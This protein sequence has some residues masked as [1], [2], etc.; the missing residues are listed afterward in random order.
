MLK[1][2]IVLL[3][4]LCSFGLTIAM[5]N[6]N[7]ISNEAVSA[8]MDENRGFEQNLGQVGDFDGNPV[9]NILFTARNNGFSIFIT[10]KGVS[11]VIY[12]S[13]KTPEDEISELP[14]S[15][16]QSARLH[17]ARI[18]LE[19]I[20]SRIESANVVYEDEL[21][22]YT[23]YYLPQCPDG[24]LF[25]K[26]YRK[27]RIKEVYPGIDWVWRYKE[28]R[29]HH[30]FELSEDADISKIKFRVKY[31]D[32]EVKDGKKLILSTPIGK[33][34]DGNVIGYEG[35]SPVEVCYKIAEDGL[36]GFDV[37]AWSRK[38]RLIIDPTLALLWGTYYG[39]SDYDQGYSITT[40]GSGNIL[41]TGWT[42]S[43]DF[44]TQD[45]GGGAYYQGTLGEHFDVFIL[46]FANTGVRV[47]AT[48]YGGSSSDEGNSITTDGSGN[49]L[50]TGETYSADFPTQDP[51]G[52]AYY[53]GTN[54]GEDDVV[55]L[56][57]T[58]TG[59]R[60]W[61]TYYGGNGEDWG[62]SITTDGS[63]NILVTGYIKSTDF[64]TQNLG[65]GAY[66]QGAN[67]GNYDAFILKFTNA[68]IRV[69]G[70]YYGGSDDDYGNSITT[71][72]SGNILVTGYTWS[73]DFPTQNPGGG[74]YYQGT[75]AGGYWD[76][77][78]LKFTNTGVRVW[79][80]YY[81]GSDYD[82]GNSIT[83]DGSG[84]I[85]VTG[86]TWSTDFPTQNPGG[87]A[88]Y[89][90]TF[91][92]GDE[93]AFILKFTNTGVRV[94]ATYYG[95][96]D[97]DY[98]YSITTDGSGNILVTGP[99][100][101]TNFP[102]QD[103]G[104][105]AYYQG[106]HAGG[107]DAFILKFTSTGER[108]WATYYGG[109]DS[110]GGNSITTDGSGNIFVTGWTQS[111]NFPTQNPGGGAYYQGTYAGGY[112]DAFILKFEAFGVGIEE[113][114]EFSKEFAL[115]QNYPNPFSNSTTFKFSLNVPA[116]VKLSA[117]NIRG[118][119]LA[120]IVDEN[121]KPGYYEIPWSPANEY[122]TLTNGI[123]YYKLEVGDKTFVKKMMLM[124]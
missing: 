89:Q 88:Y 87:G 91:G 78:I 5:P 93:D 13:E 24:A 23:N 63:G 60:V 94:W 122:H 4:V 102:T 109:S 99:T 105:G 46:K 75:H 80:T 22:G 123:Y 8:W 86:Y 58:S 36:I 112:W 43:A 15:K 81:G 11:Y 18:D 92:G 76:A 31:A 104:G 50:V 52:G 2:I 82:G 55:I 25:V 73:T 57:F 117:Y 77:I 42:R 68:G 95:G 71:D 66:Y 14:H 90:G 16:S 44:P 19:L 100:L 37:K 32:L 9:N 67:A 56:K 116:H 41:V 74:A 119:Q 54:A 48:Y 53:Q 33:I 124:R 27:V 106:T 115:Y 12:Q 38:E 108:A 26:T 107:G 101:S 85:L 7:A 1:K 30:E 62:E 17:F 113:E 61:A 34:E 97:K 114:T 96:N 120:T 20:N 83:T 65:G 51:G 35:E 49:I 40:D 121:M 110:D 28:G 69:W 118:Q 6:D 103:P 98:G 84:N 3:I 29:L 39:G 59:V 72:G 70:T 111:T 45:P 10:D 79:A 64:P 21:P 47:W